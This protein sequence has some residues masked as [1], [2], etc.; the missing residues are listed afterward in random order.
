MQDNVI[1]DWEKTKGKKVKAET[2]LFSILF[3]LNFILE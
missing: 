3:G 2:F 1:G